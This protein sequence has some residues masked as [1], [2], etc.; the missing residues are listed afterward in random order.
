[1]KKWKAPVPVIII[2]NLTVGGNGKTPLVIWLTNI[3]KK[4]FFVAVISRGYSGKSKNYPILVNNNTSYQEVGDEPIL[5]FKKTSVPVAVAPKR[6]D[7]V[8]LILKKHNV[9]LII[10]DDGLQHYALARDFEILMIN[11]DIHRFENRSFLPLELMREGTQRLRSVD[12]VIINQGVP[13]K[14]EL[15][16]RVKTKFAI[17]II[18]ESKVFPKQLNK[19]VA[20]SGIAN[21]DRF[22]SILK[23]NGVIPIKKIIFPDH[24]FF[25]KKE[26]YKMIKNDE[27]LIM[28]EKDAIKCQSFAR[29]NWWFLP[30]D[31]EFDKKSQSFL[32]EKIQKLFKAR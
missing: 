25:L 10:S 15:C 29:K 18:D 3:L 23:K 9:D 8:K 17:N 7:A 5:I 19:I 6:S 16:M 2:G 4:K 32:L 28:T 21:P 13:K 11:N 26:L 1:M 27:S 31:I 24:Y 22:F 12:V 30:I 20:I 14:K